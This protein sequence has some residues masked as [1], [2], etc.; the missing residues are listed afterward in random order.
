LAQSSL[1]LVALTM[2]STGCLVTSTPDF[3]PPK[4]TRPFLVTAS[5]DPDPRKIQILD[6]PPGAAISYNF[7][8]DVVS[9]DQ[10]E[11]VQGRLYI[12][13]GDKN[14]GGAPYNQLGV[15]PGSIDPGTM[16]DSKPRRFEAKGT[17]A[18]PLDLGCHTATLLVSHDFTDGQCPNCLNDSSQISWPLYRCNS[19][20]SPDSC[21]PDFSKTE[22]MTF[23]SGCPANGDPDSGVVCGASP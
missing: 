8:A 14:P 16:A 22:C 17:L 2:T 4:K 5:A 10:G 7:S 3:T 1:C 9:E 12:D 21:K 23:A 11:R 19:L 20:E 15:I 6:G 13:F 18:Y